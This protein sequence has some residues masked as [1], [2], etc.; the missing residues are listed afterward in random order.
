MKI[1]HS[2]FNSAIK[3]TIEEKTRL[4]NHEGRYF[5]E[6]SFFSD[7]GG[8]NSKSR[9][10]SF[11]KSFLSIAI[12]LQVG[13]GQVWSTTSSIPRIMRVFMISPWIWH[14]I[15]GELLL[16]CCRKYSMVQVSQ[17]PL[18]FRIFLPQSEQYLFLGKTTKSMLTIATRIMMITI[19]QKTCS[20]DIRVRSS[21][22]FLFFLFFIK[23]L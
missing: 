10:V 22:L 12:I 1:V 14:I 18:L 6:V 11:D 16:A 13:F 15:F 23:K 21:I 17:T 8:Y 7:S 2:N 9:S 20:I 19:I 4:C 3:K 5:Y